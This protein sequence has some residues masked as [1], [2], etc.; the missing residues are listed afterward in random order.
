MK[1]LAQCLLLLAGLVATGHAL[2]VTAAG[3]NRARASLI[4]RDESP[5]SAKLTFEWRNPNPVKDRSPDPEKFA[6]STDVPLDK[7]RTAIDSF[8]V[9]ANLFTF[10]Y[11]SA[12]DRKKKE[13]QV[14]ATM[15][16]AGLTFE[17]TTNVVKILYEWMVAKSR[18]E[19]KGTAAAIE[20]MAIES[21]RAGAREMLGLFSSFVQNLEFRVPENYR[22]NTKGEKVL[23][24]GVTMP[25]ETLYNGWGDCDTKSVLFASMLANVPKTSVVFLVSSKHLFVGIPATPRTNDRYIDI[26][27]IPYIL[28]EMTTPWA[29]GRIPDHNWNALDQNLYRIVDIYDNTR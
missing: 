27:G 25:L 29:L 23:T 19:L 7:V 1:T 3:A 16:A 5:Q 26:R 15:A 14:R 21:D 9:P 2:Q 10:S 18:A 24:A 20:K 11:S 8:G 6:M 4:S 12:A 22:Q 17:G 28:T 13:E